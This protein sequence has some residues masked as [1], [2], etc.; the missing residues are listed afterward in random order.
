MDYVVRMRGIIVGRSTLARADAEAREASGPFRP[1]IGYDLVQPVFRLYSEARPRDSDAAADE[2]KLAR[3]EAA[4]AK[5]GLELHDATGGSYAVRAVHVRDY[6]EEEGR[7]A[8]ELVV[9][10]DDP[11]FWSERR[12]D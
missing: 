4:R 11:R 8:L 6:T 7:D 1:G 2:A 5:L 9:C 3:Y 12:D 10:T